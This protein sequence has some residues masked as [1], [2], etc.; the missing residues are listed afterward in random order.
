MS[1]TGVM[2]EENWN[3]G[4][5]FL[6]LRNNNNLNLVSINSQI[7]NQPGITVSTLLMD[8]TIGVACPTPLSTFLFTISGNFEFTVSSLVSSIGI[9]GDPPQVQSTTVMSPN[10]I[11]VIFNEQFVVGRQFRLTISN[12]L[13]PL[14]IS[15]GA[16]SLYSLP[17]NSITPLEVTELTI[18]YQ[19]V[20]Y[21]PTLTLYTAEGI[22]PTAPL[23]FYMDTVQYITLTI[24]LPKILD[25]SFIVQI[26]SD[27]L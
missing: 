6:E 23:E 15:S 17:Y 7:A 1:A 3:M 24:Q 20:S 8:V 4:Q 25:P 18:P 22:S 9:S 21:T 5:V 26:S 11:K 27:A 10:L 2:I 14:E 12:I 16:I 19:T 13:N